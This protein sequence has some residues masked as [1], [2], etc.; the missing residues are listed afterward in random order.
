VRAYIQLFTQGVANIVFDLILLVITVPLVLKWR[1]RT[2]SQNLRVGLLVMLGTICIIVTCIR[3][4]YIHG[5]NSSQVT[6]SFWASIQMLVSTFVANAPTIYGS[7]KLTRRRKSEQLARRAS[8]PEAWG[9]VAETAPEECHV[10]V[11]SVELGP[12]FAG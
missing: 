2:L 10:T 5:A 11:E 8:R 1:I 3:L 9:M 7:L 4:A 6:R 12:K